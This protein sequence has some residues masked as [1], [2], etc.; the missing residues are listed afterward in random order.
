MD[1]NLLVNTKL[2]QHVTF[3]WSS[4][5]HRWLRIKPKWLL[6]HFQ[7]VRVFVL[8]ST[9]GKFPLLFSAGYKEEKLWI[10]LALFLEPL[11]KLKDCKWKKKYLIYHSCCIFKLFH[12]FNTRESI[13]KHFIYL[14]YFMWWTSMSAPSLQKSQ[15]LLPVPCILWSET[16]HLIYCQFSD[17]NLGW[18]NKLHIS[19]Q[20]SDSPPLEVLL[21]H[22][23]SATI[24]QWKQV[25]INQCMDNNST[26]LSFY[27]IVLWVSSLTRVSKGVYVQVKFSQTMQM[28]S[29]PSTH[30][31]FAPRPL[32][33]SMVFTYPL[34]YFMPG[35]KFR[36]SFNTFT[37]WH[38]EKNDIHTTLL[39][40]NQQMT[41]NMDYILTSV[42]NLNHVLAPSLSGITSFSMNF[43]THLIF[44][45]IYHC[46]C[47]WDH[48]YTL[49]HFINT[50]NTMTC[51]VSNL[52]YPF[53]YHYLLVYG[54]NKTHTT[55]LYTNLQMIQKVD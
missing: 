7:N 31:I 29:H 38:M 39:H 52:K 35:N 19:V 53:D 13:S 11:S 25:Y 22:Q 32:Q 37:Q 41:Q 9:R 10:H 46:E 54:K 36:F 12:V 6:R 20:E 5:Q 28:V 27:T 24:K 30:L 55:L 45:H 17:H 2:S 51:W 48:I 4:N 43:D 21:Q 8:Y 33:N 26:M 23:G 47:P 50:L 14:P 40:K 3:Q 16:G 1:D 49:W 34:G 42:M 15:C 18:A 44:A